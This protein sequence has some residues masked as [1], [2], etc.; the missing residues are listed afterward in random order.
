VANNVAGQPSLFRSRP[1]G[2]AGVIAREELV[3]GVEDL[4]IAYAVDTSIPADGQADFVDPDGDGNPYLTAAQVDSAAVP[5]AN[6]SQRWARV[7]SARISSLIR[8][9]E[10]GVVPVAQSYTF[11]GVATVP[12]DRRLRKVSTNVIRLRNR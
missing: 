1:T 6:A 2:A 11:N 12:A 3:E 4:R 7:V 8:T 9:N 5:G 10:D